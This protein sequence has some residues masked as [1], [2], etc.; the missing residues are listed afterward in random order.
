MAAG[1]I[2]TNIVVDLLRCYELAERWLGVQTQRI[3]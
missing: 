2:D 1:L 3:K